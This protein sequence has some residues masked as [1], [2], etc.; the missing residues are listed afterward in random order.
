QVREVHRFGTFA[1]GA[2]LQF[3]EIA[4]ARAGLQVIVRAQPRKRTDNDAIVEAALSHHAMRLDGHAFAENGVGQ[5][6]SGSNSALRAD[7]GL[8]QQLNS[9]FDDGVFARG[10]VRIDQHGL[11]Q[12]DSDAVMHQL[13]P[14]ALTEYAVAFR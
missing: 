1:D 14:F 6:A 4:N 12:L 5:Y 13:A 8:A 10:H 7:F 2:F 9:W 3:D 11:R